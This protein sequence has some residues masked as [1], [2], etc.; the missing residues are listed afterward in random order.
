MSSII[1]N[2]N[3]LALAALRDM[4]ANP[5]NYTRLQHRLATVCIAADV[6]PATLYKAARLSN[7]QSPAVLNG[8]VDIDAPFAHI[9][10]LVHVM[11][12]VEKHTD[13]I[14]EISDMAGAISPSKV[15]EI[16]GIDLSK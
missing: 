9:K 10:R 14:R 12:L 2:I 3:P 8:R 4:A 11:D 7:S 16:I 6:R 13:E 1:N 5:S 15:M